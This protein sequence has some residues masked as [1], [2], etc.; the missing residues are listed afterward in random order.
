MIKNRIAKL[1]VVAVCVLG[2]TVA[3]AQHMFADFS[4]KWSM[5]TEGPQ[6]PVESD[7]QMTQAGDAVEGKFMSEIGEAPF[8][9]TVKGD[10]IRVA[11]DVDM[12]GQML[13]LEVL[14]A[15]TEKN[16]MEGIVEA[17]GMGSFPFSA[18]RTP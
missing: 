6:G 16:K 12:G 13:S 1:A 11:F 3:A 10:S 5:V 14:G 17:A 7:L 15:L 2:G 8:K 4:G 9:G 18:V